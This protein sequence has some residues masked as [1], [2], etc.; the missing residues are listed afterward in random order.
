MKKTLRNLAKN[1]AGFAVNKLFCYFSGWVR[2]VC[3]NPFC[4]MVDVEIPKGG[5]VYRNNC[6][7]KPY[8][9]VGVEQYTP[10]LL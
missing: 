3:F 1:F 9:P 8:D 4:G 5:H 7:N 6:Q 2:C 10:P